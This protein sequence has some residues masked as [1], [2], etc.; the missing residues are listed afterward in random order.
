M[1][2]RYS[3]P[4]S[5]FGDFLAFSNVVDESVAKLIRR[6]VSDGIIAPGYTERALEIL[7]SKKGG[8]YI[9]LEGDRLTSLPS[10]FT[11]WRDFGNGLILSQSSDPDDMVMNDKF[12]NDRLNRKNENKNKN[13]NENEND[14]NNINLS[15]DS[16]INLMIANVVVKYT[17]SNSI[18]MADHYQTLGIGSGQQNRVDCVRLAGEKARKWYLRWHPDLLTLNFEKATSGKATS[19]KDKINQI[20]EF[21][22]S[23]I[24]TIGKERFFNDEMENI[25]LASD[26]F[27][28]FRDSIDVAKDYGVST[29]IQPGGSIEDDNIERVCNESGII[30]IISDRRLFH[31]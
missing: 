9:I 28:P 29:I 1:R 26:G 20:Y 8:K 23:N 25:V 3:D 17:Q 12:I 5:S 4:L 7:M 16:L 13:K 19:R 6:E 30:M 31:H 22:Q 2:A 10:R 11:E 21:I 27:F 15:N 24:G 14:A 18:V